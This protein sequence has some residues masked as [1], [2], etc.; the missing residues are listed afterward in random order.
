MCEE[1]WNEETEEPN[2]DHSYCEATML[3][4]VAAQVGPHA[5]TWNIDKG[6]R[7]YHM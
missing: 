1:S 6:A 5:E 7:I 4:N 2:L 3:I